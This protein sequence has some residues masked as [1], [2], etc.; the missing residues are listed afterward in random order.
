VEQL[1]FEASYK[2]IV[3]KKFSV[4]SKTFELIRMLNADPVYHQYLL[5][6]KI[7]IS[8]CQINKSVEV[9]YYKIR[10]NNGY[11]ILIPQNF[12]KVTCVPSSPSRPHHTCHPWHTCTTDC[13]NLSGS[14][15]LPCSSQ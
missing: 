13:P 15:S 6:C 1:I 10:C 8:L 3:N 2:F 9:D 12:S 11:R 4:H 14:P 7:Y 5:L